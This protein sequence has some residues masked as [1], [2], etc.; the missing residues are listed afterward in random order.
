MVLE[1]EELVIVLF[2]EI[3]ALALVLLDEVEALA[4]VLLDEIDDGMDIDTLQLS[5]H[6]IPTSLTPKPKSYSNALTNVHIHWKQRLGADAFKIAKVP[7][8]FTSR[9]WN[10]CTRHF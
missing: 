4:L 3:K 8:M 1:F 6:K 9:L 10:V 7:P 5:F 2:N